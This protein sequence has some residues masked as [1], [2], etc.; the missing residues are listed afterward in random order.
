VKNFEAGLEAIRASENWLAGFPDF[1]LVCGLFYMRYIGSNPAKYLSDVPKI[2]QSFQRALA[3]G[4]TEKFKSVHGAGSFLAS[5][6]LGV[7]YHAFGDDAR[8]RP[9]LESAAN[10]NYAPAAG[11]LKK[12]KP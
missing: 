4:E 11:L 5:Y 12:L 3:L 1:H 8:A 7:F 6:N 9:C 2:E 10:Q